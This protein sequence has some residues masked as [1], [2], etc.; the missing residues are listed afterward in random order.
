VTADVQGSASNVAC[1]SAD[2]GEYIGP[3]IRP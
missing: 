1:D 2:V 3:D